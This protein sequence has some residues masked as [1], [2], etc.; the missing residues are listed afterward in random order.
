MWPI[1]A[2]LTSTTTQNQRRPGSHGNERAIPVFEFF[3]TAL[4]DGLP[5][6]SKWQ[7]VSSSLQDSS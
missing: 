6:A 5:L 3:T 1:D 2:I 7:Q 4:A